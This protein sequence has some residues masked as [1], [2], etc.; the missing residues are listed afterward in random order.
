MNDAK[1]AHARAITPEMPT[2]RERTCVFRRVP[3]STDEREGGADLYRARTPSG[4]LVI[5]R[6]GG[7][8]YVPDDNW[9]PLEPDGIAKPAPTK[10][11]KTTKKKRKKTTRRKA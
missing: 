5:T 6:K 8:A 3:T 4:W 11:T 9:D 7:L 10:A 2:A 1:A